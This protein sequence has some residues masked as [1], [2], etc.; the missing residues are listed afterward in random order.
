M[1]A[2]TPWKNLVKVKSL[3]PLTRFKALC[4][5]APLRLRYFFMGSSPASH[6]LAHVTSLHVTQPTSSGRAA[7][8]SAA[9]VA[10]RSRSH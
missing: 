7:E 6:L 2:E 3:S 8:S 1:M 4:A 10:A 5:S 9:S